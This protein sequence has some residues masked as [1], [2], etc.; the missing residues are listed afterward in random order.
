MD[1]I[2][3]LSEIRNCIEK[4]KG[5]GK[6]VGRARLRKSLQKMY[7]LVNLYKQSARGNKVIL[8]HVKVLMKTFQKELNG[9]K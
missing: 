7:D 3:A 6:F 8:L 4:V 1:K 2:E 5:S 9:G